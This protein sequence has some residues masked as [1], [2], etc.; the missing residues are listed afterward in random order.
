MNK[1]ERGGE[2]MNELVSVIIPTYRRS[3]K[4]LTRAVDSVLSQTYESIEVIIVDDN[5][6]P[7]SKNDRIETE[8][9][10][11][12]YQDSRII[13]IQNKKNLG[14]S[15]SRNIGVET[16]QGSFIC[17]LDD[18]DC[19]LP[20]KI[21]NQ[22][23]YMLEHQLEVCFSNLIYHN[24]DE[25]VIDVRI[26][27]KLKSLEEKE[28]L[29]Y[30]LTRHITGTPTFMYRKYVLEELG[31]F[32]NQSI[33]EEYQLMQKTIE[34]HYKIG[35]LDALD[36]IAYR[37]EAEGLSSGS[38]K[39]RGEE[40]LYTFKKHHFSELSPRERMFIRFRHYSVVAVF[41]KRKGKL[42]RSMMYFA[43]AASLSPFD[44]ISE[45]SALFNRLKRYR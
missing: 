25:K 15:L 20:D 39:L 16:A 9:I 21:K 27:D 5:G 35:Y 1:K 2:R 19:Y 42:I 41:Y 38:E 23:T 31:G 34:G 7:E 14:V 8:K 44:A 24:Q 33:A 3:K 17:F 29:A 13:Y 10:I 36:V 28:L 30:H 26:H 45:G 32:P 37:H 22:L 18:D 43:Y 6:S 12:S 4:F 11:H 40:E